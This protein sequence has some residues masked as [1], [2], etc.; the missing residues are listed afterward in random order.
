MHRVL[1]LTV[2]ELA[3]IRDSIAALIEPYLERTPADDGPDTV[4]VS[5]LLSAVPLAQPISSN[6]P[7]L[8]HPRST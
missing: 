2:E 8:Q 3:G 6:T 1:R 7:P 5:W 4:P